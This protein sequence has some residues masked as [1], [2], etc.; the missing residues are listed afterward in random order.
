MAVIRKHYGK[1]QV[2]IRKKNH[3]PVYRSFI[4]KADASNWARESE[5]NIERGVYA[6]MDEANRTKLSELLERYVLEVSSQKRCFHSEKY[7]IRK[8]IGMNICKYTLAQLTPTK[9]AK[10]RDKLATQVKPATVNKYLS[11][12][13]V[14]IN[15]AR[16]EWNL[17]LPSNPVEKLKRCKEPEP[18]KDR[19]ADWEYQLLLKN[20][21]RSKLKFLKA[22]IILAM[23][24]GARRGELLKLKAT[25][26]NLNKGICLL[27]DT[28]NS[29]SREIGLSPAVKEILKSLPIGVDGRFFPTN[30]DQFKFYWN[31]LRRWTGY[32]K[33]WHLF[34]AEFAT[35]C[36]E[37]GYDISIVATQ[38]GWK[39]WKALR[40]YSKISGEAISEILTNNKIIKFKK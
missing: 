11:H 5:K 14:A 31:Q 12:I 19:I 2:V 33:K 29:E 13:Q 24:T 7:R 21:E 37:K 10:F 26:C 20:A 34:R 18:S 6:N 25:D 27:K 28:K 32:K 9:V 16:R 40:R 22:M 30:D 4:S 39:D 8:L 35:R 3:P 1:W 36:F 17:Y 23:E 38:G 15:H